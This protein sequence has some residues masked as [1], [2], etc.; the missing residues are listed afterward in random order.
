MSLF[1][2]LNLAGLS[3]STSFATESLLGQDE[4]EAGRSERTRLAR[5]N[6]ESGMTRQEFVTTVCTIIGDHGWSESAEKLFKKCA[7]KETMVRWSDLLGEQST[8]YL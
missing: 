6:A 2:I 1:Y 4:T 7:G 5:G 3:R 8:V